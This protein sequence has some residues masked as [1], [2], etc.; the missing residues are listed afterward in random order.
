MQY[1][2]YVCK[3]QTIVD[4]FMSQ[5]V[6][7]ICHSEFVE[8]VDLSETHYFEQYTFYDVS[9]DFYTGATTS[10]ESMSAF[11]HDIYQEDEEDNY[12]DEEDQEEEAIGWDIYEDATSQNEESYLPHDSDHTWETYE[13]EDSSDGSTADDNPSTT[14]EEEERM[15]VYSIDDED[16]SYGDTDDEEHEYSS[17]YGYEDQEEPYSL[18]DVEEDGDQFSDESRLNSEIRSVP[19]EEEEDDENGFFMS[20]TFSTR[21]VPDSEGDDDD[22]STEDDYGYGDADNE[23]YQTGGNTDG[24]FEENTPSY[25]SDEE[26][27]FSANEEQEDGDLTDDDNGSGYNEAEDRDLFP[28][29]RGSEEEFREAYDMSN[30]LRSLSASCMFFC[31]LW[32]VWI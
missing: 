8:E 5:P 29:G 2:C 9:V 25:F 27:A 26:E 10:S 24:D 30:I 3:D 13:E 17:G 28:Y 15:I 11:G 7:Q 22:R 16:E 32:I 1:F 12:Y 20:G 31:S 18:D 19:G 21:W 4:R 14:E 6:C 23:S